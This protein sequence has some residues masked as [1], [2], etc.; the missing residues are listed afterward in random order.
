VRRLVWLD[1]DYPY[2]LDPCI[3]HRLL[4]STGELDVAT[5][6]A[7][8]AKEYD[9]TRYDCVFFVN[10]PELKSVIGIEHAHVLCRLKPA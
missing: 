6:E 8:I 9:G 7:A 5:I 1:N 10:P 3:Q 4:W 2:A